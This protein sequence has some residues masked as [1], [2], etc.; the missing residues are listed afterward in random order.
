[1]NFTEQDIN[2]LRN[3]V[4][5]T[6]AN[7][8]TFINPLEAGSLVAA[9][10]L[11][12]NPAFVGTIPG[13]IAFRATQSGVAALPNLAPTVA[14]A[15]V[16]WPDPATVAAAPTLAAP[17]CIKQPETT[18]IPRYE[19]VSN[20]PD[21]VNLTRCIPNASSRVRVSAHGLHEYHNWEIDQGV[22]IYAT[23]ECP[24]PRKRFASRVSAMNKTYKDFSPPR[25]FK[26]FKLLKGQTSGSF[27]AKEA[28]IVIKRIATP[29]VAD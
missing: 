28:C 25:Y 21:P 27:I 9:G 3:A 5:A 4:E 6:Q 19:T 1:M 17:T 13:T 20:F 10:L 16:A 8:A 22:A 14:T 29:V 26:S 18:D 24:D 12:G 15:P 7:S 23:T 2:L 11:E